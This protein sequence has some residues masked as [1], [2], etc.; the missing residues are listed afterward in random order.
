[1][2]TEYAS[3]AEISPTSAPSRRACLTREFMKTVQRVPRSHGASALQAAR[4]KS[5]TLCPNERAKVSMNVP[6][7]EE[8]ASLI[9]MLLDM[10]VPD[11]DRLHVLPADIQD[12]D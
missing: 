7:P 1:M 8:Q 5:E 9:S 3:P 10:P 6:H 2:I 12:E 4:A 11:E